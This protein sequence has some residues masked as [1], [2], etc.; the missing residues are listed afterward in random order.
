MAL[1]AW[2]LMG[3]SALV[4]LS[5]IATGIEMNR[6]SYQERKTIATVSVLDRSKSPTAEDGRAHELE[7][8][9]AA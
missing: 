2:I 6:R 3:F 9:R 1:A 8:K 5:M 4:A 7:R